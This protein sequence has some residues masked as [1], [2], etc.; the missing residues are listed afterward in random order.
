MKLWWYC[1]VLSGLSSFFHCFQWKNVF[2]YISFL[3]LWLHVEDSVRELYLVFL[4]IIITIAFHFPSFSN[5]RHCHAKIS[6][7]PGRTVTVFLLSGFLFLQRIHKR[8][9]LKCYGP[10]SSSLFW[11]FFIII[12][13]CAVHDFIGYHVAFRVNSMKTTILADECNIAKR[14]YRMIWNIKEKSIHWSSF[15]Y[16]EGIKNWVFDE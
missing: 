11:V 8:Q 12:K 3:F 6:E 14:K 5:V 9:Q 7:I 13:L 1:D 15:L 10:L 2:L 16:K 4:R